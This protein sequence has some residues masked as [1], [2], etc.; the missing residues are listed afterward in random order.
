MVEKKIT[1]TSP[2]MRFVNAPVGEQ[3]L[4]LQEEVVEVG[5]AFNEYK[6]AKEDRYKLGYGSALYGETDRQIE[7]N[8]VVREKLE[9]LMVEML[10]VQTCINTM[11][12][13]LK[14][15]GMREYH[16]VREDAELEV[17]RKN[18][19][20]GYYAEEVSK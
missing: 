18:L 3:I 11:F 15:E 12:E 6:K 9:N 13:Q 19:A 10:D 20:R 14:K 16:Y 5:E 4:K 17:I 8:K 7:A 2:C 1:A